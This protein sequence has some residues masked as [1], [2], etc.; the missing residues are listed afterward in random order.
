MRSIVLV[1]A[2]TLA[3]ASAAQAQQTQAAPAEDPVAQTEQL[4]ASTATPAPNLRPV[5]APVGFA[6]SD[7]ALETVEFNRAA[8]E[9]AAFQDPSARNVLAIVGAVVIIVALIVLLK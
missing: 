5:D 4:A 8:E 7:A 2:L 9:R 1:L 6:R 3:A